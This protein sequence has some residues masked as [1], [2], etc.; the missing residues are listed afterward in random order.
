MN[1]QI[2]Q[3]AAAN[4]GVLHNLVIKFVN[5]VVII[6]QRWRTSHNNYIYALHNPF[7]YSI[8]Y[9]PETPYVVFTQYTIIT[10]LTRPWINVAFRLDFNVIYFVNKGHQ[11]IVHAHTLA[12]DIRRLYC[13]V[14]ITL[15]TEWYL[16]EISIVQLN[17]DDSNNRKRLYITSIKKEKDRRNYGC[18]YKNYLLPLP[19]VSEEWNKLSWS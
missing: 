4:S 5:R 17:L 2:I 11:T 7:N 10:I 12:G 16:H 6:G 1:P 8:G 3:T 15:E 9:N 19:S 18:Q 13:N 14:W